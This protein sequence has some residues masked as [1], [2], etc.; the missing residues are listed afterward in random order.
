MRN[1]TRKRMLVT[2]ALASA[3][4]VALAATP[5]S[6]AVITVNVASQKVPTGARCVFVT[7]ISSGSIVEASFTLGGTA[8]IRNL[9]VQPG[10]TVAFDWRQ[11]SNCGPDK[12]RQD[13][14]RAPDTLP[15]VWN[16]N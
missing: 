15:T 14:Y 13:F 6:A 5:A 12:V 3:A 11:S 7:S 4:T 8:T 1:L 2:V 10:E 16:I 9:N